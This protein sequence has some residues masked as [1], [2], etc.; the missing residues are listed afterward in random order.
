MLELGPGIEFCDCLGPGAAD[1][2]LP[3]PYF[4]MRRPVFVVGIS[5]SIVACWPDKYAECFL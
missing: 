1:L 2:I 5:W 4:G 3:A